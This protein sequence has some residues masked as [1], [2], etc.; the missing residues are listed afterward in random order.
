MPRYRFDALNTAQN[1]SC[2]AGW[3]LEYFDKKRGGHMLVVVFSKWMRCIILGVFVTSFLVFATAEAKGRR[4]GFGAP[5]SSWNSRHDYEGPDGQIADLLWAEAQR[6]S[7]H[8]VIFGEQRTSIGTVFNCSAT[9][10]AV[11]IQDSH[12]M[13]TDIDADSSGNVS[14]NCNDGGTGNDT[15]KHHN[16]AERKKKKY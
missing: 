10:V 14:A 7:Q 4:P 11:G 15:F 16:G 5:V 2:S 8:G 1:N 6:R 12:V 3:L 9:G 13:Q